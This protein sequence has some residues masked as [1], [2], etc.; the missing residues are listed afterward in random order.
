MARLRLS[1]LGP[2]AVT[3]DDRAIRGLGAKALALLVYLAL[4]KG[5]S[6]GREQ[7]AALL[8]P[9]RFDEQARQSLRQTLSVLRKAF[10]SEF[11][12]LH[13]EEG[14]VSLD[15]DAVA[16][17]IE[18]LER[19]SRS[20]APEDLRAAAVLCHGDFLEAAPH[21]SQAFDDW[22]EGERRRLRDAAI[23]VFERLARADLAANRAQEALDS[24]RAILAR[25]PA[26]E[27]GHRLAIEALARAGNKTGALRQFEA[28]KAA[29]KGDLDVEPDA[30]TLALVE[31]VRASSLAGAARPAD[32]A[33]APAPAPSPDAAPTAVAAAPRTPSRPA[34]PR[35]L[36]AK[37]MLLRT[38]ALLTAVVVIA[39]ALVIFA[40]QRLLA[41]SAQQADATVE[42]ASARPTTA[43]VCRPTG[44][45][46]DPAR[47]AIVVL[48]LEHD[49]ERADIDVFATATSET[50]ADFLTMVPGLTVVSGP[51]VGHSEY[52]RSVRELAAEHGATHVLSGSVRVNNDEVRVSLRLINGRTGRAEWTLLERVDYPLTNQF[53]AVDTIAVQAMRAAQEYLTEGDQA[54][55]YRTREVAS[56][57]VFEHATRG[58]DY[59]NRMTPAY[60]VRA[61]EEYEAALA[62]DPGDPAV[63][64]GLGWSYLISILFSWSD[65]QADDLATAKQHLQTA[66]DNDPTYL[67]AYSGQG[68]AALI[69]GD[70]ETAVARAEEALRVSGSGA[71]SIAVL[72]YILTYTGE[73]GR[74]VDLAERAMRL[75]PYTYPVWYEWVLA[76][77]RRLDGDPEAALTCLSVP[78][79]LDAGAPMPALE[80]AAALAETG[81]G[82]QA[83]G[84]VRAIQLRSSRPLTVELICSHPPYATAALTARCVADFERAGI[85][86]G[87]E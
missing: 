31:R 15:A 16:T 71:D 20:D 56:V 24:A 39:L 25:D 28:C 85:P 73:S 13:A 55:R 79:L 83:G 3:L 50:V 57:E 74:A 18:E 65:A 61:R 23:G 14:G 59:L 64:S 19:L 26:H 77:T 1:L 38:R 80:L 72:A 41:P 42:T 43:Q 69:E 58:F 51:P 10:E 78:D 87:A 75:R 4:T 6:H 45:A 33:P 37:R 34:A 76:R 17:D 54:L 9:D 49:A 82:S 29:L 47:P 11:E 5:R 70:H 52:S 48:P 60:N 32:P 36:S 7:L 62:I 30:E 40:A 53:E 35:R 67:Y 12:F 8:W 22:A 63:N 66:I 21:V 68:V 46:Q 86:S 81:R 44:L 27:A 84:V 2:A